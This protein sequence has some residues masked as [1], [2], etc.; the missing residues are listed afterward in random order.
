MP[1]A[2]YVWWR[3]NSKSGIH[4]MVERLEPPGQPA[5]G[6]GRRV[7]DAAGDGRGAARDRGMVLIGR[8]EVAQRGGVARQEES[9]R[10]G[11][12]PDRTTTR[13]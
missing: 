12:R 10:R 13:R 6:P 3:S 1:R 4:L 8:A 11:R 5:D 2:A 9:E 7:R